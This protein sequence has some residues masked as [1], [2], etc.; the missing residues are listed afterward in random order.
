MTKIKELFRD[1]NILQTIRDL[2]MNF[3]NL[4]FK[5]NVLEREFYNYYYDKK[6]NQIRF[7]FIIG[8]LLYSF[9]HL[10]DTILLPDLLQPFRIIRFYI[11]TPFV[12]LIILFSFTT[13]FKKIFQPLISLGILAAGGG[14]IAMILTT[15]IPVSDTYYVGVILVSFAAFTFIGLRFIWSTFTCW[16]LALIY[17]YVVVFHTTIDR[18]IVINNIIFLF[19]SNFLGMAAAYLIE[20]FIRR[21]FYFKRLLEE[22]NDKVIKAKEHLEDVVEVRTEQLKKSYNELKKESEEKEQLTKKQ[23]QL[24]KQLI[25]SQ[26]MEAIGLLAGGVAH[27]FNNLLTVING[28]SELLLIKHKNDKDGE[29]INQI[30]SAG[31]KA[32]A[33]TRQLLAFSRKQ[34][35]KQVIVDL[36]LLIKNIEMMLK[37]LVGENIDIIFIYD[38]ELH[39]IMADP[40]Q[41]EQV[42]I[43]LVINARDAIPDGGV[44]KIT[45]ENVATD[46]L[47]IE[48]VNKAMPPERVCLFITDTGMGMESDVLSHIF[49]PFFTTKEKNK[50]T[51]LGLST[52]YGI[53]KQTGGHIRVASELNMGTTFKLFFNPYYGDNENISIA[54][55][56]TS[57]SNITIDS[58][59]AVLLVEDEDS[60]RGFVE[61]ILKE[62]GYQVFS[63]SNGDDGFQMFLEH[64]KDIELLIVDVIMPGLSGK[65]L[66]NKIKKIEPDIK[67]IYMS[68]YTDDVLGKHGIVSDEINIIQKPFTR[69]SFLTRIRQIINESSVQNIAN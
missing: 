41:L 5:D 29:T 52:V 44:I 51:G 15:R 54:E 12:F 3:L 20:Y 7:A 11:V 34:V 18:P 64:K 43:N 30:Y 14:I 45:T 32:E 4:S 19:S 67:H 66:V 22:A 21:D 17:F 68:G 36:N 55:E 37:H 47:V 57:N 63:A 28:Y 50:G 53:V 48:D 39:E 61:F 60:V 58:D 8:I 40:G 49:E 27:D 65:D 56:N 6:I 10:L 35:M 25:Q 16:I 31:K 62:I 9:F 33:L 38:K 69:E 59:I 23:E 42:I 26:K 46:E 2:R 1:F 13:Y 24:Q